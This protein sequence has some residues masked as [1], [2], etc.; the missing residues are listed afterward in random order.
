M[1]M[2]SCITTQLKANRALP[3]R[4][5]SNR[6][7]LTIIELLIVVGIILVLAGIAVP[8]MFRGRLQAQI[9]AL[10]DEFRLNYEAFALYAQE[11]GQFPPSPASGRLSEMPAGMNLYMPKRSTWLVD[12]ANGSLTSPQFRGRWFWLNPKDTPGDYSGFNGY[13]LFGSPDITM[14]AAKRVDVILDD[15][16]VSAGAVRFEDGEGGYKWIEFG[17]Q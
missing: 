14:D 12:N 16:D 15:G 3:S 1:K 17:I 6:A 8:S 7:G 5:R 4:V 13:I 2:S 10:S 11:K 9:S